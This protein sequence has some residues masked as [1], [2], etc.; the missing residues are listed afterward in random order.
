MI[1]GL[2]ALTSALQDDGQLTIIL[3]LLISNYSL[4]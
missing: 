1:Q 3:N 2:V 4:L